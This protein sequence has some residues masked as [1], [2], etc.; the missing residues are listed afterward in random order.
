VAGGWCWLMKIEARRF[1]WVAANTLFSILF[2]CGPSF[3]RR[4][5]SKIFEIAH[6]VGGA[7]DLQ[8]VGSA[9]PEVHLVVEKG[10][11]IEA[12]RR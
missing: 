11:G 3:F 12:V 5:T 2:R 8:A 1:A 6:G 4:T 10:P 9:E 7:I